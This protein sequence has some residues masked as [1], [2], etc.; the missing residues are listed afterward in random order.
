[1]T[2][3]MNHEARLDDNR[4]LSA[5]T[6]PEAEQRTGDGYD[7][8]IL[9]ASYKQSLA[10]ARSLGRIG[11][12]AALGDSLTQYS[13]AFPP[14]AFRSRYC[15]HHSVLPAFTDGTAFAD[16]VLEFVREHPTRVI[17]PTGDGTI[18]ALRPIRDRLAAL[19][20]VLA[21][22]PEP[23]LTIA[24]DKSLTLELA[25]DL[26]ISYPKSV[27]I[28]TIEDLPTALAEFNFPFVLKPTI[29]WPD[30]APDRVA[31]ADV[32]DESEA[33]DVIQQFL[34]AGSS[35]LAQEWACGRREGVTLLIVDGEVIASCAHVAHRTSPPLGGASVMRQSIPLREDILAP[36][37]RLATAMGIEGPC[38][39][40]FRRDAAGRPLLME[41]NARLSGTIENAIRS[42]VDFPLLVW[43]WAIGSPIERV[44]AYRAGVR[45]RWLFGEL[46]WLRANHSRA[47][48][49]D[50]VSRA[51]GIYTFASEFG[52]TRHYDY[53]DWDDVRPGLLELRNTL[54]SI[55]MWM[56]FSK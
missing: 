36:A 17:L 19:G 9:D 23:A 25:R 10:A 1:M 50:S 53:L 11:L 37:I 33:R 20:C 38:E 34:A 2:T 30:D 14:P 22:A 47:G 7:V 32:I 52:R 21:L 45:T 29:S 43:L 41:V 15:A 31:A 6:P 26:G 5:A 54:R 28:E 39:V 8:L 44:A 4:G 51:R 35:V 49:P 42:G 48:R 24:N 40:E 55:R 13:P 56:D 18:T 3:S 46:R 27:R 16:A 12:R